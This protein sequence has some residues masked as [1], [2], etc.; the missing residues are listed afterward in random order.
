MGKNELDR[1]EKRIKAR[2]KVAR[3]RNR[4]GENKESKIRTRVTWNLQRLYQRGWKVGIFQSLES[5]ILQFKLIYIKNSFCKRTGE[6]M[7]CVENLRIIRNQGYWHGESPAGILPFIFPVIA[8]L[9]PVQFWKAQKRVPYGLSSIHNFLETTANQRCPFSKMHTYV[10]HRFK[11]GKQ[12]N[13]KYIFCNSSYYA[14]CASIQ[15]K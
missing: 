13:L 11:M 1:E 5:K 12:Y 2:T 7:D 3:E 8:V 14:F 10:L 4:I 6:I 9:T 15:T